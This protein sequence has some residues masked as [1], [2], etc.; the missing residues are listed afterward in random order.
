[1]AVTN[2][3]IKMSKCIQSVHIYPILLCGLSS[4]YPTHDT[5]G[6]T[7]GLCKKS[8]SQISFWV[9]YETKQNEMRN[10]GMHNEFVGSVAISIDKYV[11]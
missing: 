1:M 9:Y 3:L 11:L 7:C 10:R 2:D 6:L 4:S 5:I 8:L